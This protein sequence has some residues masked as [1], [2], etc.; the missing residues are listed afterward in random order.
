MTTKLVYL[1]LDERPCNLLYPQQLAAMTDIEMVVPGA[2]L[3]GDKKQRANL[4]KLEIWLEEQCRDADVLI[5]SIDMLVHG[6]IVPSRLHQDDAVTCITRLQLFH[7]LKAVRPDLIIYGFNLITRVPAYS[8]SEEEPEYY[9]QFGREIFEWGCLIDKQDTASLTDEEQR[10]LD[11]VLAAIP[12]E[13]QRDYRK[14]RRVNSDV[15][16][17]SIALVESG[18][19][20]YLIIPLDDNA[21]Y[22]F[23]AMEQRKLGVRVET[24]G[25]SERVAIYPGA[26]EIGCTLF[27]RVFCALKHHTPAIYVR[28]SSTQGPMCIPKYEDR[29][30]NESIKAHF[31]A[32][33]AFMADASGEADAILM[34]HSPPVSQAEMAET[35]TPIRDRNRAYFSEVN[36]REFA[37]TMKYYLERGRLVMLA[38]VALCNGGDDLL[39]KQLYRLGLLGRLQGYAAWNTS[40]NSLGTVIAHAVIA[41]YYW[42]GE[43]RAEEAEEREAGFHQFQAASRHFYAYRL[44]EDWGYQALVRRQVCEEVLPVLGAS[45]FEL[46]HVQD[47]VCQHIEDQLNH[48]ASVYLR[49]QVAT[50]IKISNVT[51]PWHRMFEV[52]FGLVLEPSDGEG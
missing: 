16:E 5:A 35:D 2:E 50:D 3:L 18:V 9:D 40:G 1:P 4:K 6:G 20:D 36:T 17:A 44:V 26:D 23:S 14:R 7:R 13:V 21:K 19:L 33:G 38:D 29:S 43:N 34:V 37:Q 31:M 32:A 49:G 47:Q 30:L 25:L 45:Y 39:M 51:L 52:G 42:F 12:E 8:S 15:N 22:G 48:F 28:Y 24:A 46:S 10:R 11:D 27:A 41:S